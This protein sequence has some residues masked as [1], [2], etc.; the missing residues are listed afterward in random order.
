MTKHRVV[1]VGGGFGGTKAALELAKNPQFDV[2][3]IHDR[4]TFNYFPTLYKT[5]TGTSKKISDIKF[6][7]IFHDLTINLVNNLVISLDPKAHTVTT[8]NNEVY[9]YDALILSMGVKTNFFGIK[10]LD[11]FAYSIKTIDDAEKFK[12]HLHQQLIESGHLDANYVIIGGGPTGVELA[13]VL[14][15]YI[16]HIKKR[17]GIKSGKVHVDLIEAAPRLLPRSPKDI[18][19]MTARHLRKV[20]VKIYLNTKVQAENADELLINNRSIRSHTVVWTAGV[21]NSQFYKEHDFQMSTN[22]KVRVDQYLQAQPGIYVIGDNADTPYSGMAQTAIY[23]GAFV[24]KN[25][26][27]LA[28]DKEPVPY[29]AKQPIYVFAAGES[30]AAVLWGNVRIYGWMGAALRNLADLVG[31]H[32]FEPWKLAMKKVMT[33][34]QEEG[35]CIVCSK[36]Q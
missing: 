33:E 19:I 4:P 3:L 11:E 22:G 31:F 21:T 8:Q 13:G 20:G 18:S 7:E 32:D 23:D 15:E 35:I 14:P 36:R 26:I 12:K 10:G 17:H 27:L 1:I 6:S 9:F 30:W 24:A 29:I 25:L 28:S 2:T 5:A 34:H 16:K